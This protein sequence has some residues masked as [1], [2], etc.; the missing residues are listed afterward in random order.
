MHIDYTINAP[1]SAAQFIDLLKRST[2]GERRPI[3]DL[4]CI[5]GM[6]ANSNLTV[7]AWAG[8]QLVGMAR[9]LTD[10]H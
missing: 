5:E 6:L 7:S 4:A 9:A 8:E 10:F 1:V 2:L 3:D